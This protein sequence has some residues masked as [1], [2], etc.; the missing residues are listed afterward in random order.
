MAPGSESSPRP[1]IYGDE[2]SFK[3][4]ARRYVKRGQDL[5]DELE[6]VHKR[7]AKALEESGDFSKVWAKMSVQEPWLDDVKRFARNVHHFMARRLEN[8]EVLLPD[9]MLS[10]PA[11]TPKRRYLVVENTEPWLR[12]ALDEL[13]AL[14]ARLG[15]SKQVANIAAPPGRF[16]ELRISGLVEAAI[17]ESAVDDMSRLKTPAQL[18]NAIGAAKELVEATLRGALE[19]M[20]IP[21]KKRDDLPRLM[22]TWRAAAASIASPSQADRNLIDKVLSSLSGLVTFTAEWRNAHGRGHGRT[23]QQPDL[24][25]RHARL[26]VDA[27][28]AA[29]RFIVTTLDD[30]GMLQP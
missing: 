8:A 17:V 15:V 2:A 24:K 6:G 28:E 12:A 16:E 23:K 30:L 29:V 11:D 27:A 1:H 20:G 22:A 3:R 4:S 18:A 5:L 10:L 19:T 26:A 7:Y 13:K 25:P 14:L 9:T 21:Y